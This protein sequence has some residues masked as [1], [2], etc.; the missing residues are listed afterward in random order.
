M[1]Q[2]FK[3]LNAKKN[4]VLGGGKLALLEMLRAAECKEGAGLDTLGQT[5]HGVLARTRLSVSKGCVGLV[6]TEGNY[7]R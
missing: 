5:E 7:G 3:F 4:E 2:T 1:S 6:L